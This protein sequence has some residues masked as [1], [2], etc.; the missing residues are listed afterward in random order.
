MFVF[1][2]TEEDLYKLEINEFR[3]IDTLTVMLLYVAK[4]YKKVEC[5]DAF[6]KR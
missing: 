4:S 6:R 1:T 5:I 2:N 3:P